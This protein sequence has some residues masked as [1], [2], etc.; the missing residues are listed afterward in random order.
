MRNKSLMVQGTASSVGKSILTAGFCRVFKQDGYSVAPFKSQNMALNSYIT[1][2]G[3][4]M[5]RAQVV[6]A[7]AACIK[8]HVLMNPILLKPSTDQKAQVIFMGKVHENMSAA[9]YHAYKPQLKTMIKEAYDQLADQYDIVVLEGAGSPAEIN[10]REND[11]VN[12]GM[13]ELSD[14]P[15]VLVADIDRGGVFASIYG[16]IMLLTEEERARVKGVIINKFRGD[17]NI[18]KDG[19]DMIEDLTKIPVLGVLPYARLSIED[20]D[21]LS[22][23]FKFDENKK[24]QIKVEILYLPHVSNFTDFN[25]FETQEDVSLRYVMRGE[26][27]GDPDLLIIPGSKN[28]IEDLIYLKNTGLADQIVRLSRKGKRIVGICG[29]Y[30]ML[31]KELRDPNHV[32]SAITEVAGLGLLNTVTVFEGEKTT[33]QVKGYVSS[34]A[35]PSLEGVPVRGYEIHMGQTQLGQGTQPLIH[36]TESLNEKIDL[37]DGA[38]REDGRVMGSYIH[39]IFDDLDFTRGLL[40]LIRL[41]KGLDSHEQ[42]Q[43]TF[44]EFKDNEY[45][46]LADLIRRHIDMKKVYE[47]LGIDAC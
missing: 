45:N 19:L 29:G 2:E 24:G 10:L 22:E 33:T 18:L 12:M 34:A 17:I 31:G 40:D 23:R 39:G 15:V 38:I 41:E 47:I 27:I 6:Q 9:D 14:S 44:E 8:P 28:T 26:S 37:Y 30:Q 20:E 46:K 42:Q 35:N 7:E 4:E 43:M 3:H 32:E 11:I 21:S 13:A 5:G 36:M 1:E 16:T 25:M